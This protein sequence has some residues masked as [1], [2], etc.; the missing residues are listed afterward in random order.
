MFYFWASENFVIKQEKATFESENHFSKAL[1]KLH[2]KS[3][4]I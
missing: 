2:L 3:M 1:L 4:L